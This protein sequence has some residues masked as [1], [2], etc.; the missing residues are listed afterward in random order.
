MGNGLIAQLLPTT[1]GGAAVTIPLLLI[2]F[3]LAI[4][5]YNIF[6]HPLRKFPGPVTSA[7][8]NIPFIVNGMRGD[9]VFWVVE[10]HQKYGEVVR[11][12]P[13]ELSFSGNA[14]YKDIHGHKKPGQS[15]LEKDPQFYRSPSGVG[16]ARSWSC[17]DD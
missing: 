16:Q 7:I 2:L 14:A 1:L 13:N 6:F 9:G 12:A 10:L 8:S 5:V 11:V 17:W 15:T 3:Q 4:Y